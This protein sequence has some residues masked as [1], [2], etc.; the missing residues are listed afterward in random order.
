MARAAPHDETDDP[1]AAHPFTSFLYPDAVDNDFGPPRNPQVKETAAAGNNA[2]GPNLSCGPALTPLL[3]R[4]ADVRAALNGMAAWSRGGTTGNLG[5]VWGWRVL[6]PRWRGLWG[7]ATPSE[8]PLDYDRTDV[9]KVVVMLT[10][11]NNQPNTTSG[12]PGGSDFTA[13]GRLHD[14]AGSGATVS[15][16]VTLLNQKLART[17]AAMKERGI[18]IYTITFGATPSS[19]T[20]SLYRACASQPAF[21][22]HAPNNTTLRSAF[23]TIGMQ[24]SKLRIKE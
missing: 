21:Y 18:V 13:Y 11:G 2:Y 20:Q 12:Q 17:C 6:S 7:G 9:R 4:K 1:P 19:S 10:D 14:F 3:S 16:G 8:R 23:R 22:H 24:L 5:M 15:Q